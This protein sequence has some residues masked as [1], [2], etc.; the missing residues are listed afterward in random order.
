M[1]DVKKWLVEDMKFSAEEAEKMAPNFTE[2]RIKTLEAGYTSSA[3]LAAKQAEIDKLQGQWTAANDK[4][5][6]EMAEWASLTAKE[7]TEAKDLQ[8]ALEKSRVRIAQ[9]ETRIGTAATTHGFDA[10][11]ILDGTV[12]VPVVKKDEPPAVDPSKF[13]SVE[14][15]GTLSNFML[16]LPAKLQRIA[17]EHHA[18]TGEYL[19]TEAITGEIMARAKKGEN[20]DPVAIWEQTHKIAEKR[21]AKAQAQIDADKKLEY[22]RGLD[23]G[24]SQAALPGPHVPG[25]SSPVFGN[26]DQAGKF[27]PHVSK[28]QRPQPEQGVRSAAAAL[29]THKYRQPATSGR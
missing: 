4:L 3:A 2:E 11:T 1:F 16:Q 6:Q 17:H 10:K 8:E 20:V 25:R 29:A 22:E 19:D 27:T 23:E 18:L 12:E 14:Q 21:Q 15:F 28:L 26:R 13:V 9:L 7:K 5:N 24:R